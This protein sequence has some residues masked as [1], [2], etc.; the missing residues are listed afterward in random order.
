MPTRCVLV[1][2]EVGGVWENEVWKN[3]IGSWR[4][5]D[6]RGRE[7]GRESGRKG[8]REGGRKGEREGGR[9]RSKTK[10]I[11]DKAHTCE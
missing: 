2:H 10:L 8:E 6:M 9:E 3:G 7:G 11:S 4:D 1:S 5:K